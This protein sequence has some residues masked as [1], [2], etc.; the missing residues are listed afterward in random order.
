VHEHAVRPV[1]SHLGHCSSVSPSSPP[2]FGVIAPYAAK[3]TPHVAAC[4]SHHDVSNACGS[5]A[6]S[7][8]RRRV[9]APLARVI[10]RPRIPR[11]PSS[12]LARVPARATPGLAAHVRRASRVVERAPRA[13]AVAVAVVAVVVVDMRSSDVEE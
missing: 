8:R 13:V 2:R 9:D 1:P 4:S 11:P 10:A 3:I 6:A 7:T 12:S 5:A